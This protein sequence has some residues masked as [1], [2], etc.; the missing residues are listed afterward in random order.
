[1]IELWEAGQERVS[2]ELHDQADL[3][4]MATTHAVA[5]VMVKDYAAKRASQRR[6]QQS[7]RQPASDGPRLD[8][9]E[10][11]ARDFPGAVQRGDSD[12]PV[13]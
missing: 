12:G 8:E 13:H 1:M 6:A 5:N 4:E 10:R 2:R 9:W 11:L 7:A 3:I